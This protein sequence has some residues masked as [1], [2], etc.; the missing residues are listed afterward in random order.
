MLKFVADISFSTLFVAGEEGG[1]VFHV[2]VVVAGERQLRFHVAKSN[3]GAAALPG[4]RAVLSC[5][6]P[7]AYISPDWYETPD[8]VPTWNYVAVEAEG[9]L[10]QLDEAELAEQLDSL[11]AAEEAR[12]APKAPWT[13]AKMTPGRFEGMMKAILGFAMEIEALRGTRK[14]AQHKNPAE[15][16]GAAAGVAAAGR[17]DMAALMRAEAKRA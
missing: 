5:L 13:R 6:G 10:R 4:A 15:I 9:R 1:F 2:P 12:L 11:G 3:R 8:Q 7:D 17:P 16:E 14:L